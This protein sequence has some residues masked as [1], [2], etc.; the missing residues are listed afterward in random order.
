MGGVRDISIAGGFHII[1]L[2]GICINANPQK[3]TLKTNVF[4]SPQYS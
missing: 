3:P 4:Y 2:A 1:Q